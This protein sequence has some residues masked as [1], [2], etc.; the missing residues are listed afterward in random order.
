[1]ACALYLLFYECKFNQVQTAAEVDDFF[2]ILGHYRFL[3][4]LLT[5]LLFVNGQKKNIINSLYVAKV[6]KIG[7]Y[8]LFL[9]CIIF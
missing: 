4:E 7:H 5:S 6:P 3:M 1:M 9:A 2:K 8:I